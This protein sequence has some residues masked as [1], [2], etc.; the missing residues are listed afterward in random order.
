MFRFSRERIL[1]IFLQRRIP[2]K[3][4]A[5]EAGVSE[6]VIWKAVNGLPVSSKVIYGIAEALGFNPLDFLVNDD[7]VVEVR[8]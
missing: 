5:N 8:G 4:L 1:P 6:R 3:K 2:V 7:R